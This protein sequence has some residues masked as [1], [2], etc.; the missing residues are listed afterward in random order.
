VDG[1]CGERHQA[2]AHAG[3]HA[4]DEP[5]ELR[6]VHG[7]GPHL[8]GEAQRAVRAG[9]F[10]GDLHRALDDLH[11]RHRR[12]DRGQLVEGAG[13]LVDHLCG[14]RG[15]QVVL[16]REVAVDRTHGEPASAITSCID[17]LW[18]PCAGSTPGPHR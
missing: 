10:G 17:V 11:D 13:D 6:V 14:E 5:G 9:V 16:A 8:H 4:A 7:L 12:L 2:G 18:K 1:P 15:D 3:V